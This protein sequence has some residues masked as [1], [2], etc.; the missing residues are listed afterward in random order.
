[1]IWMYSIS[2]S[3]L[4]ILP[5]ISIDKTSTFFSSGKSIFSVFSFS[6]SVFSKIPTILDEFKKNKRRQYWKNRQ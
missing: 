5:I 1:M 2:Q 6:A 4:K 3:I